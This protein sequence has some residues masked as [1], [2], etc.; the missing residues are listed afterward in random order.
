MVAV[1]V[2][3]NEEAVQNDMS[4]KVLELNSKKGNNYNHRLTRKG[5]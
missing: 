4:G 3:M 1:K 2:P 5:D